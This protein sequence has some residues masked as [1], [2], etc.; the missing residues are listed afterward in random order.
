MGSG[1]GRGNETTGQRKRRKER[2]IME[3]RKE[4]MKEVME[5]GA[6]A[7]KGGKIMEKEG[8]TLQDTT[9]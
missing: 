3:Q 2:R 9:G 8:D 6:E 7:G 1:G 4:R 5:K